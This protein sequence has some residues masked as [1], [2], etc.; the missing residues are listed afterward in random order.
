MNV[1]RVETRRCMRRGCGVGAAWVR[2]ALRRYVATSREA[3]GNGVKN[4]LT[5]VDVFRHDGETSP[6]E[7]L[8]AM[9]LVLPTRALPSLA[10]AGGVAFT[11]ALFLQVF[12][13]LVDVMLYDLAHD[14]TEG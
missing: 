9:A 4:M 1:H 11:A 5:F 12:I 6:P 13:A 3:K 8:E 14:M 2:T 10:L 7:R